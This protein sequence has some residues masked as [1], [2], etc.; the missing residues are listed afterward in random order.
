MTKKI[1]NPIAPAS[2]A[3][4]PFPHP[5]SIEQIPE[6]SLEDLLPAHM[7][8]ESIR[9]TALTMAISAVSKME[10]ICGYELATYQEVKPFKEDEVV[11]ISSTY[12]SDLI[13]TIGVN[14]SPSDEM[15]PAVTTC[16][17]TSLDAQGE[18]EHREVDSLLELVEEVRQLVA[19]GKDFS[20]WKEEQ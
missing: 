5:R 18:D 6:V 17:I 13:L 15:A 20:P 3:S 12:I 19:S 4:N 16:I 9:D 11:V 14:C 1:Y 10:E 2:T 8:A 7:P